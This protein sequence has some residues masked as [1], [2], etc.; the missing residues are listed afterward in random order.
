MWTETAQGLAMVRSASCRSLSTGMVTAG[1]MGGRARASA[2]WCDL[3]TPSENAV[4][5]QTGAKGGAALTVGPR[6]IFR[7]HHRLAAA[8]R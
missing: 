5:G 6:S 7:L 4:L 8:L 3:V 1:V 2:L